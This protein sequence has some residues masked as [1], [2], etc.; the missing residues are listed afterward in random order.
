M[1]NSTTINSLHVLIWQLKK[2]TAWFSP[3]TPCEQLLAN[4]F[5]M[6]EKGSLLGCMIYT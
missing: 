4:N 6:W 3:A 5:H 2:H 1:Y